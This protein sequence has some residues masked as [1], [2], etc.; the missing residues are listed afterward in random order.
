M[1]ECPNLPPTPPSRVEL[2]L[3]KPLVWGGGYWRHQLGVRFLGLFKD[4]SV[5][6]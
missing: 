5:T 4:L 2:C 6:T 3:N 1:N